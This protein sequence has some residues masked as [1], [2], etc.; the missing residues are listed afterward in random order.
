MPEI[1]ETNIEQYLQAL[2]MEE[3]DGILEEL[4]KL[5]VSMSG[6]LFSPAGMAI[7]TRFCKEVLINFT[8]RQ[9][10]V[11]SKFKHRCDDSG[12]RSIGRDEKIQDLSDF[13]F[14]RIFKFAEVLAP[15]VSDNGHTLEP[16]IT[17]LCKMG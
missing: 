7:V 10:L 6:W 1:I 11:D 2:I 12:Y 17:E 14:L 13:I 3:D 15:A 4:T 5:G 9:T 16:L 8:V